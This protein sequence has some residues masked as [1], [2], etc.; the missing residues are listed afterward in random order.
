M[1]HSIPQLQATTSHS[2]PPPG[3]PR[4]S[5]WVYSPFF[6]VYLI[7]DQ[8]VSQF[9]LNAVPDPSSPV[10]AHN[11][12]ILDDGYYIVSRSRCTSHIA[13]SGGLPGGSG[14]REVDDEAPEVSD[15]PTER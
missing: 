7:P 11:V 15:A 1:S 13:L 8:L 6:E 2:T 5:D 9:F 12:H 14:R 10:D 3:L 4:S